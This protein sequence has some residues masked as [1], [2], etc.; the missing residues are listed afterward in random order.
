MIMRSLSYLICAF[1][2]AAEGTLALREVTYEEIATA[3]KEPQNW[4][5]YSGDYRGW[6]YSAL[7]RV[8]KRN[9]KQLGLR[10]VFN[11]GQTGKLE[12]TPLVIDSIMYVPLLNNEVYALDG[13]TGREIW[14][15]RRPSVLRSPSHINGPISR[16]VAALGGRIYLATLD[17]YVVALDART[18]A[19]IWE[20]KAAEP[21]QGYYFTLA[22]LAVKDKIVVGVSGGEYGIR[23]FIDAYDAA[24]GKLAWRFYTIPGPGEPGNETWKGDTWKTGGGPAWVTGTYDQGLN[25]IY[26]GVGNPGPDYYGKDREGDNLYTNSVVAL[27]TDT[28]K[29]RWHFQFTPH[30][31]DDYDATIVPVLLDADVDGQR[32][33]LLIEANRN[34]F[35][36]VLDRENGTFLLA[37]PFVRVTWAKGIGPDG[38][39]ILSDDPQLT[40]SSRQV[41]PGLFGG[42]NWPSPSYSPLT[43][44][45]YFTLR[46]ECLIHLPKAMPYRV[47]DLFW[48]GGS[49]SIP[50]GPRP[51]G[52]VMAL[53]PLTGNK[54]WE[55]RHFSVSWAGVLTTAGGLVFSGD[56]EG[57]CMALNALTGQVLWRT[58]LGGPITAAP[59]T[60]SVNG[61]QYVAIASRSGVFAFALP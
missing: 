19:L 59:I 30:D 10:W 2:I 39:P 15:Y 9:V 54:K 36:Y 50:D 28:G 27:D 17:A 11:N 13:R 35:Y 1:L 60:Y 26:W 31:V 38:R 41:C 56:A 52:A 29:L 55:F 7:D 58:S 6:R 22:P 33:K 44:L 37:K 42:A 48:G 40:G 25:L 23:G 61:K 3:A 45:F 24:T 21:S 51:S 49:K 20:T 5:T 57:Y 16:G 4:L 47:G 43:G 8:N 53:N 46:D 32:R 14:A 34:G 18:G 12:A